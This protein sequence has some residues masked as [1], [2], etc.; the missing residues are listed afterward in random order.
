MT[1]NTASKKYAFTLLVMLFALVQGAWGKTQINVGKAED[2][3]IGTQGYKT[4]GVSITYTD[5]TTTKMVRQYFRLS[6]SFDGTEGTDYTTGTDA[7]GNVQ[8][9]HTKTGTKLTT[10]YGGIVIGDKIGE[11]TVKVTATRISSAPDKYETPKAVSFKFNVKAPDKFTLS[12]DNNGQT[13]SGSS[14]DG[15]S[16]VTATVGGNLQSTELKLGS[17]KVTYSVNNLTIDVTHFFDI[18]A[19]TTNYLSLATATT[20]TKV[21]VG[22]EKI[23]S[24][25]GYTVT[26]TATTSGTDQSITF[27]YK[28]KSD[29]ENQ[30][31]NA[32][33]TLT[34]PIKTT[35][36]S[37]DQKIQTYVVFD[38]HEMTKYKYDKKNNAKVWAP[39]YKIVDADGNDYTSYYR[40]LEATVDVQNVFNKYSKDP[41]D[42]GQNLTNEDGEYFNILKD[43]GYPDLTQEHTD[44]VIFYTPDNGQA[45]QP[46]DYII[47]FNFLLNNSNGIGSLL[48][49]NTVVDET[50]DIH[51]VGQFYSTY[52]ENKYEVSKSQFVL[53]VL[54]RAPTLDLTPDPATTPIAHNYVMNSFN[55]F[56]V[57]AS[58]EDKISDYAKGEKDT[59]VYG[60]G[61]SVNGE[62]KAGFKYY[63][64]VPDIMKWD[65]STDNDET[66]QSNNHVKVEVTGNLTNSDQMLDKL[67]IAVE[68]YERD[69]NGYYKTDGEGNLIPVTATDPN[70]NTYQTKEVLT[71]TMYESHKLWGNDE[72]SWSIIFHGKGY[73]PIYYSVI[74]WTKELW[75][76][77]SMSSKLFNIVDAEDVYFILDPKEFTIPVGG[78]AKAPTAKVVDQFWYK[79]NGTNPNGRDLSKYYKLQ[80]TPAY[81][82]I[83][84]PQTTNYSN[85]SN[86][87]NF[88]NGT[89]WK[90]GKE[91]VAD[92]YHSS[93]GISAGSVEI[94]VSPT[95]ETN[96]DSLNNWKS[97]WNQAAFKETPTNSPDSYKVTVVG[98]SD[99]LAQYDIIYDEN[100]YNGSTDG[101]GLKEPKVESSNDESSK[102]GKLHFIKNGN[103]YPGT[104]S[105]DEAPGLTITFGTGNDSG[106]PWTVSTLGSTTDGDFD[107]PAGTG[108][109]YVQP[110]V[111]RA[112]NVDF[113][114]YDS[115]SEDNN[116]TPT[117]G[118]FLK[119]V[120]VTNGFL[121]IDG[122]FGTKAN[123][124]RYYL[125]DMNDS[126]YTQQAVRP[127]EYKDASGTTQ[128]VD[129]GTDYNGEVAFKF[130]LFEG[131]TYYL[132]CDQNGD[133]FCL[134]GLQYRPAFVVMR[135]DTDPANS[136]TVFKGSEFRGDMPSLVK[137]DQRPTVTFTRT[138]TDWTGTDSSFD[139]YLKIVKGYDIV[140]LNSYSYSKTQ[141]DGSVTTS[142]RIR[143]RAAVIGKNKTVTINGV[144]KG[145]TVQR[146]PYI[147]VAIVA[148]PMYKPDPDEII[149]IGKRVT[150]TNYVTRM[151]MTWGGWN[152]DSRDYPYYNHNQSNY[153]NRTEERNWLT[154][155]YSDIKTD[156]VGMNNRTI[157][158]FKYLSTGNNNPCDENVGSWSVGNK[159]DTFDLPVRGTYLKFE[160]GESGTLMVHILQNGI[161]DMS[162]D[163]P[164]Y[165][166][167][168]RLRRRAMY[169]VDETGALV[170]MPAG[171]DE[172]RW[173]SIDNYLAESNEQ[174]ANKNYVTE[175]LLRCSFKK[176]QT[177]APYN[178]LDADLYFNVPD[179]EGGKTGDYRYDGA[180]VDTAAIKSGWGEVGKPVPVI[181]LQD[182]GFVLPT[183]AYVR[184]TFDVKAGKTYYMFVTGSKLGCAG[185][186]FVPTGFM[187]HSDEWP[188]CTTASS[189]GADE[190]DPSWDA[191]TRADLPEP[192]NSN[193]NNVT[194]YTQ[195][196][197]TP[198]HAAVTLY[199]N[200]DAAGNYVTKNTVVEPDNKSSKNLGKDGATVNFVNITL[201]RDFTPN[202]WTSICLPFSLSEYQVKQIFGTNSQLLTFDSVMTAHKE[203]ITPISRQSIEPQYEDVEKGTAHFTQHVNQLI[204]AGRP[205][206][207]YPTFKIV[208]EETDTESDPSTDIVKY[209]D[210]NTKVTS[211]VFKHVSLEA[212]GNM[213]L[214]CSNEEAKSNYE[215][216]SNALT[217]FENDNTTL[218]TEQKNYYENLKEAKAVGT[219]KF[220]G[221]YDRAQISW[222]S[223]VM[224]TKGED[225]GLYRIVPADGKDISSDKPYMK[226][227]RAYLKPYL[228][229]EGKEITDKTS[230]DDVKA[231]WI[232]GAF[233]AGDAGNTSDI[234]GLVAE[235]NSMLT[236]G[237]KGVFNLQGQMVSKDNSLDGLPHGVYIMNGKKYLVE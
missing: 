46:D 137:D 99:D 75:D 12:I 151:W 74:S 97:E 166:V 178:L 4:P 31:G 90:D 44:G 36:L 143:A 85:Y 50:K 210:D 103:F 235:V 20:K 180:E 116:Y 150:T 179:G 226:G 14:N 131:H 232:K 79:S 108:D 77:G 81:K 120:P 63:Y 32:K 157:D 37:S 149:Y 21:N 73:I 165:K 110:C 125:M 10:K 2:A 208:D 197:D 140:P 23:D 41:F 190:Y 173:G 59:L 183:K 160:P 3:V 162:D 52:A 53:H 209:N 155:S 115:P 182:G 127:T 176:R 163:R 164:G 80:D 200:K 130:P 51:V 101:N 215:T 227:F 142:N 172:A 153:D 148:L 94:L 62:W 114:G 15:L 19:T 67:S 66:L 25:T 228:T 58:F 128:N 152:H 93:T 123:E 191:G 88:V 169:I 71:G 57:G 83:W 196:S 38:K 187:A 202:K 26:S 87:I 61:G 188:E 221:L 159:H 223:Y 170:D 13:L 129:D 55:R 95:Q 117:H 69:E 146:N 195:T 11:V 225:N 136:A 48:A 102:M 147:D 132:W 18:T 139:T 145:V 28:P 213:D 175:A 47:S 7:D 122:H 222:Y 154:D 192:D 236:V 205:Y 6:Y 29:Y 84:K 72:N 199:D 231:M 126:Y 9:T 98:N 112:A 181:K 230:E 34:E 8:Q 203:L 49:E 234:E 96:T 229:K 121:T 30:Y 78:T 218:T 168:N 118:G 219:Y 184:Y 92:N 174:S 5:G 1:Q 56:E 207:I 104:T 204:E 189:K 185:F 60:G 138:N 186:A 161:T 43:Q 107:N 144:S 133:G 214:K 16:L 70:G 201:T 109:K 100:Y 89:Q 177:T 135:Q 113:D 106:D 233:V 64:F 119:L 124:I 212:V 105:E 217:A 76:V 171:K 54:R 35:Y 193:T 24:I 237:V 156:T 220:T 141:S 158:G 42:K 167:D 39:T 82:D 40:F 224:G 33:T 45:W 111:L 134:H 27:T 91:V 68:A 198:G 194:I 65:S 211:I 86:Y 22:T 216:A 17:P 206:F